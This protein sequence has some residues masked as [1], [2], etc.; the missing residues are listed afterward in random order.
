MLPSKTGDSS[1]NGM[2]PDFSRPL[3]M[4]K[5]Y[6]RGC[7]TRVGAYDV[8]QRVYACSLFYVALASRRYRKYLR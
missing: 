3:G 4:F 1:R 5:F 2:P 7:L 8:T 6:A